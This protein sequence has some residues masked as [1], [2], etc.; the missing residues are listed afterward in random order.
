MQRCPPLKSWSASGRT[1]SSIRSSRSETTN[2]DIRDSSEKLR[3]GTAIFRASLRRHCK[4]VFDLVMR[5]RTSKSLFRTRSSTTYLCLGRPAASATPYFLV[6]KHSVTAATMAE[7]RVRMRALLPL[8]RASARRVSS[9]ASR[10]PRT[11]RL[12][13]ALHGGQRR[14]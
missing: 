7:R 5:N 14:P 1:R 11:N 10:L 12:R 4:R 3:I 13:F 8:W 9:L 6:G 2:E